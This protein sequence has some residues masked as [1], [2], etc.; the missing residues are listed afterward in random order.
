ML[1]DGSESEPGPVPRL[2]LENF[3]GTSNEA[4]WPGQLKIEAA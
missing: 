3:S 1:G 4:G 2:R